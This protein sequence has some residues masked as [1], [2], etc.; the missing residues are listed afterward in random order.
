MLDQTRLKNDTEVP[1]LQA[2]CKKLTESSR[3]SNCRAYL[4]AICQLLTLLGLWV[5]NDG[6]GLNST[7]H[8]LAAEARYLKT[9]LVTLEKALEGGVLLH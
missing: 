4:S 3:P 5:S 8:Q 6:T 7:D 2:H 1:Q 9:R